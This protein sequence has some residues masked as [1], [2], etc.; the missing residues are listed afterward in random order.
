MTQLF[1][2]L[3]AKDDQDIQKPQFRAKVGKMSGLV[4]I[5]C[6]L[7]LAGSKLVVGIVAA[8]VSITADAL[9]NL[10]DAASSIV[11]LLGF[12]MAEKPADEEHPYGHARFEY[13]SGL[14]VAVMIILIGFE[15]ARSSVDKILHPSAVEM[16]WITCCVLVLSIAV[17]LWLWLF[18]GKLSKIINSTT[19]MATAEDSRNDAI[20]TGAVLVAAL[21]E[22]FTS[23]QIDGFMGLAV[24]VFILYSGMNLAKQTISPLLGE[25]A[26]S[27]MKE[28]IVDYIRSCPKVLGYHDLMVHDYGPGQ[29]FASIHVEMDKDE[30]V[31]TCHELIDDM[32]R[33]CLESHGIH[34]VIHYDP[35]VTNDP[36]LDR[37]K[38]IVTAVLKV[39]DERISIHDF[40]MVMGKGHT[41]LIFDMSLPAELLGQKKEIKEALEEALNDLGETT[42][43]TVITFDLLAFN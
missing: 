13:L 30:D 17:K 23:L 36:E 9:N 19:L 1:L 32:E 34:L 20:T 15:L 11:T 35:I 24:A 31:L 7:I 25:G 39:R 21:I 2:N 38:Q 18:N 41:N 33:E 14:A 26:N 37:M 27:E 6:N 40:R 16:T 12:K 22:Y 5:L 3:L 10:S 28:M 8:S 29:R 43:H 42:Y 4:G